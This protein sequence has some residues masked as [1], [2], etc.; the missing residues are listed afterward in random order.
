MFKR[1]MGQHHP[2][3]LATL[4]HIAR[5]RA[6]SPRRIIT[7]SIR[8][9]PPLHYCNIHLSSTSPTATTSSPSPPCTKPSL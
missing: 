8:S 3:V 9:L 2:S 1:I 4:T 5:V 7:T 6:A